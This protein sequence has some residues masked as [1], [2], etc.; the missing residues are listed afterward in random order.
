[1]TTQVV[2]VEVTKDIQTHLAESFL[3]TVDGGVRVRNG[4]FQDVAPF[5]E[6]TEEIQAHSTVSFRE[7][8]EGDEDM[9]PFRRLSLA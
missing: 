8:I 6:G 4:A 7:T 9:E 1:M 3:E 5:A 2:C